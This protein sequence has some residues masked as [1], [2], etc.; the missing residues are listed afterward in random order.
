M[1]VNVH[2]LLRQAEEEGAGQALGA[3]RGGGVAEQQGMLPGSTKE[4][5]RV[6]AC[7]SYSARR[8]GS[9]AGRS[10]DGSKVTC[11]VCGRRAAAVIL[12]R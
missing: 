7:P 2:E 10:Y 4:L 12:P 8:S 1:P 9:P 3:D 5:V 6:G 11:V